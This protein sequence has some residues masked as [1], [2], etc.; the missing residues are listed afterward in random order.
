MRL[1]NLAHLY[2]I[3][4]R[5]R[6]GQEL[7][8]LAG[9]TVGV[10]LLFSASVADSSLT[11]SIKQLSASIVGKAQLELVARSPSGFPQ[12]TLQEVRRIPGVEAAAPVLEAPASIVGPDGRKPVEL[13]GG[14]PGLAARTGSILR[15]L[16]PAQLAHAQAIGLPAP[17]ARTIGVSLGEAARLEIAGTSR[18]VVVAAQLRAADIG[19]LV[20]SPVVL[21]PLDFAQTLA[22][23]DHRVSRILITSEPGR[24]AQVAQALR[25][26][27]ATGFNV[28]PTSFESQLFNQAARPTRDSTRMFS[29]FSALVGFV[30]A[31]SAMLLTVPQR[32]RMVADLRLD[33]YGPMAI[34][35]VLLVDALV[36]GL[37][38][39]VLGLILGDQVSR[40]LMHVDPGYLAYTFPVGTQ[41]IVTV[42]AA[43]LAAAGGVIAA[44]AA[45]LL[46]FRDDL[47]PRSRPSRVPQT[48]PRVPFKALACAAGALA[49]AAVILLF[50]PQLAVGGILALT[51][52]LCLL[53]PS[54]LDLFVVAL[55]TL[56]VNTRSSAPF[57]AATAL[58]AP[59]NRTRALAVAVTG[60]IA[61]MSSVAIQGSRQDLQR[62]LDDSARHVDSIADLWVTPRSESNAFATVSFPD[63]SRAELARVPGVGAVSVYRGGFLDWNDRRVWVLAPPR[64]SALPLPPSQMSAR[65]LERARV[66][67]AQD[68]W[69]VLSRS[70][71]AAHDL[72]VGER[73][74]S[75][76]AHPIRLRVAALSSNL[77]W[78][79]GAL[80]LNADDYARAW[81]SS[82]A[83]AYHLTLARHANPGT[84]SKAVAHQLE[85]TPFEVETAEEREQ[86]HFA[87]T[88]ASLARLTHIRTLV[89][90]AAVLA[91]ATAMGG[92]IWQRRRRLAG[93]KVD[94]YSEGEVW[95]GLVLE[96]AGLLGT[97]CLMGAAFGLCGQLLLTHALRTITGFPVIFSV[98]T[99][100]AAGSFALVTAAAAL[101]VAVP[102][103]AAARVPPG[104]TLQD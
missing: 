80:I 19:P 36:L 82:D 5:T 87:S 40:H 29:A 32:R 35:Q 53:L 38:A 65:D 42:Q 98:G 66:R 85:G 30:F 56:G 43:L 8:A 73:F 75:P 22:G 24:T 27:H 97:A 71:A 9:I 6:L 33:G 18:R 89:L 72:T 50:A 59:A 45:V 92:M 52:A 93:L 31:F 11:G 63:R 44:V 25:A 74:L 101:M 95:R 100:V 55:R 102:G 68:G 21:A 70:L 61:V 17:I 83:S 51:V 34:L 64:Q 41:R 4:L 81:G 96:S 20:D 78:P 57:L 62:G 37:V 79:S 7:A 46:P 1:S 84:V 10:A 15:M 48:V 16:S 69:A 14:D 91:M 12:A 88:R 26:M 23:Q 99:L 86:R 58:G 2:R 39:S 47:R 54:A 60:A 67:L 49:A 104:L 103:Y 3:R 90:A 28:R 76:T 77:G 94:G 13:L